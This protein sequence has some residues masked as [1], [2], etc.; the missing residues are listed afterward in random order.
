MDRHICT[1]DDPWELAKHGNLGVHPDA[2]CVY[3]GGW[4]QLYERYECPN[5]GLSFKVELAQ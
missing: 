2:K 3:D 4:D 1:K 5:C